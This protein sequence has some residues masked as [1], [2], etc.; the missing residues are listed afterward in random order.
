MFENHI[1]DDYIH[2]YSSLSLEFYH[3]APVYD[4]Y[5]DDEKGL[6][7]YETYGGSLTNITLSSFDFQQKYDQPCIHV[8][9]DGSYE[10]V[11]QNTN[12]DL[13]I[14]DKSYKDTIVEESYQHIY[15][16]ISFKNHPSFD[17][18]EDNDVKYQEQI[19]SF[20][21]KVFIFNGPSYENYGSK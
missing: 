14:L 8:T 5:S 16:D 17:Y 20:L 12:E 10:F 19:A 13:L 9:I 4:E 1:A 6:N 18:Y 11:V 3:V 2:K 15:H 21:S 7:V